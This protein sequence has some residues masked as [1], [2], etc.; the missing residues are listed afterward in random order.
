M[1]HFVVLPGRV[2]QYLNLFLQYWALSYAKSPTAKTGKIL[3]CRRTWLDSK[4]I[5][6]LKLPFWFDKNN[7]RLSKIIGPIPFDS[8]LFYFS[9][10]APRM[11]NK[12]SQNT[13][14]IMAQRHKKGDSI[15][16]TLPVHILLHS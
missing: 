6:A 13:L 7:Y 8:F 15:P 16:W 11:P 3:N 5:N 12:V 2:T 9:S 1:H 14:S 10:S 4:Y